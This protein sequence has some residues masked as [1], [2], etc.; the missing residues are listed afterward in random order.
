MAPT[1]PIV[2]HNMAKKVE[3]E[4]LP[5]YLS[6]AVVDSYTREI[7]KYTYLMQPKR[8]KNKRPME[9]FNIK[10]IWTTCRQIS[11]EIPERYEHYLFYCTQQYTSRR[12]S[13]ILAHI[14]RC[15]T[16]KRIPDSILSHCRW[17]LNVI[18]RKSVE[19][20]HISNHIQNTHK[21]SNSHPRRKIC[22]MGYQ[23]LL[24]KTP[25]GWSEYM[26]THIRI[27]PP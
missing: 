4:L 5:R 1:I 8:N 15:A 9:K 20:Y 16:I 7:L 23:K 27:I 19:K 25:M 24:P 17:K 10:I 2:T 22:M 21:L 3:Y 14:S 6:N 11:I 12:N 26:R 18:Y 13:H